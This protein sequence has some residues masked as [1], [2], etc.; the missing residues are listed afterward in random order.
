MTDRFKGTDVRPQQLV[1]HLL[2]G[3]SVKAFQSRYPKIASREI[4]NVLG[5]VTELPKIQRENIRL[6]KEIKFLQ[7]REETPSDLRGESLV[8]MWVYGQHTVDND[9]ADVFIKENGKRFEVKYSGLNIPYKDAVT[10][11]WSWQKI[12]GE[13]GNKKYDRLILIGEKDERFLDEYGDK[14]CPWVIFDVPFKHVSKVTI[15]SG[16]WRLVQ[17]TTNPKTAQSKGSELYKRYWV[18]EKEIEKRYLRH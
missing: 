1:K 18:T 4:A 9:D 14:N 17:L 2:N 15:S 7:Q 10:R 5:R 6:L 12:L 16:R 8:A 13:F 11:R 3:G